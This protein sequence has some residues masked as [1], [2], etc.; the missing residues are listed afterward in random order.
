LN[1]PH[2]NIDLV[3]KESMTIFKGKVLDF[4]GLTNLAPIMEHLGTES[5]EIEVTWEFKDLAFGTQDGRG[6]H[7]EEEIDL[8]LDDLYRCVSYN[9]AL[10]RVHKREFITVIFV[11]NPTMLK[12]IK[13]EQIDFKPVIVQCS[14]LDA[15]AMLAGLK[16]AIE[17][18]EV[19]NELEAIYLPL[20][21]SE[22][23][24]PTEL[25]SESVQIIKAMRVDDNHKRKVLTLLATLCGKVVD[26]SQLLAAIEEVM[27][28]GNVIFEYLEERGEKRK[29]EEMAKKMLSD[30]CDVLNIIRYTG[31]E[32]ERLNELR[33]AI[34]DE[35][36]TV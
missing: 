19:I 28:M 27:K 29:Q 15:D 25:F 26:R 4:L 34:R 9:S 31:I 24:S 6:L 3:F 5:V 18:G 2:T 36:V 17:L 10:S 11:K 1:I 30:N 21:N 22:S 7:F 23:L 12:G 35:A 20:F 33:T 32:P 14:E 13:T 8:S 16:R